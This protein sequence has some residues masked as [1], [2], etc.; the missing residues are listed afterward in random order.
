MKQCTISQKTQNILQSIRSLDR[1]YERIFDTISVCCH[2]NPQTAAAIAEKY[3][4]SH[5]DAVRTFLIEKLSDSVVY[6]L[7]DR[8]DDS[9]IQQ[10]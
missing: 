8:Y 1:L 9:E 4:D 7:V 3:I 2:D 10:I 6:N 5:I